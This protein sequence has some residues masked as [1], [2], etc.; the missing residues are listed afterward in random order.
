MK[1]TAVSVWRIYLI[2]GLD[3]RMPQFFINYGVRVPVTDAGVSFL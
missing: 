3:Y 2:D 1:K